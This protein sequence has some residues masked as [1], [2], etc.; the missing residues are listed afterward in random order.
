MLTNIDCGLCSMRQTVLL[1]Y[2]CNY[3][4]YLIYFII[5]RVSTY[6]IQGYVLYTVFVFGGKI[7]N[8]QR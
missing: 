1:L 5:Q 7:D 3:N 2:Y 8:E 4:S 6:R